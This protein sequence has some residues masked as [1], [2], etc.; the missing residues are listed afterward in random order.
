MLLR[1]LLHGCRV[2]SARGD[3]GMDIRGIAYDSRRVTPGSVFVAIQGLRSDGNRFIAQAA[4]NGAAAV[5]SVLASPG[6]ELPWIQVED[7]RAALAEMAANFHDRPTERLHAIGITGTNGKTTTT[8]LV[9]SILKAAGH[10]SS[11]FG[12]IEY[13]GPGFSYA[14]ERTTPEASELQELFRR[15]VDAG[16]S[17]GVMEVSSHAIELK[18]VAGLHFDVAVFTNL[19]RDHLDF[20]HDMRSYFLAKKKLFTGLDGAVPRVLVL[21]RDDAQFDELRAIGPDRVVSYAVEQAADVFPVRYDLGGGSDLSG[22]HATFASPAGEL[23]IESRLL[24]KTNLYNIGAAIGAAVGLSISPE[25][26]RAGIAGLR[27]VPGRF[28]LVEAGQ[29][30]RVVVDF[31]HTDDALRRV[32]QSARGFT[33]GRL[34]VVFGC[35]GDRDRTKR[36]LMG[37]V[38]AREADFTIVTSDNPRSEDPGAILKEVEAGVIAGGAPAA[39]YRLVAD[40]REA[41]RLALSAAAPGDTVVLAGKGHE[42]YQIIGGEATPFDDR[43]VSLEILHELEAGRN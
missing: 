21:N 23:E 39:N 15:V 37:E 41:I 43:A 13:R 22:T 42:T 35:G 7:D 5:V 14:A 3:L 24:G 9:E 1:D 26:I 20:H 16:W 8:Y 6:I 38:A 27:N 4:E 30:F 31:A 12:T 32:L 25:A 11:V 40:R 2:L 36:P 10:E 19:T 33:R 34:I 29:R 18:R 28:E 17:Y